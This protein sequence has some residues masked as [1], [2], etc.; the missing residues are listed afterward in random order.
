MDVATVL[1][2]QFAA[3]DSQ[4]AGAQ[5]IGDFYASRGLLERSA[6]RPLYEACVCGPECWNGAAATEVP[7]PE[8][9]GISLPWIGPAYSK[10]RVAILAIN[11][12]A[13]GGLWA[14]WEIKAR[15]LH[16]L[17]AGAK[18]VH[19]SDFAYAIASYASAVIASL[20]D[21]DLEGHGLPTPEEGARA[22]AGCSFLQAVKCAPLRERSIPFEE[23]TLNCPREYLL[24]EVC[25]LRPSTL[26]VLGDWPL[27]RLRTLCRSHDWDHT[28]ELDRGWIELG[29]QR[30]D[31]VGCYHPGYRGW[32]RSFNALIRSL[33]E[34]PATASRA[35][36]ADRS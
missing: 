3:T 27:Q 12:V 22:L 28:R 9:A 32:R 24:D 5:A 4:I 10:H 18:K 11:F 21:Q 1:R 6:S 7:R 29:G 13:Y 26:I 14:N 35:P 34:A 16:G 19:N 33:Q 17:R 31:V 20:D 30:I 36:K 23:M 2:T 15:E 8:E 25:L